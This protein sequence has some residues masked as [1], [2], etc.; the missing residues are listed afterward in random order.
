MS[1]K[2][3]RKAA[4]AAEPAWSE[5]AN[6]VLTFESRELPAGLREHRITAHKMQDGGL[7]AEWRGTQQHAMCDW[8]GQHLGDWP[9]GP[10]EGTAAAT[11]AAVTVEAHEAPSDAASSVAAAEARPASAPRDALPAFRL[12]VTALRPRSAADALAHG[13]HTV[14][15]RAF[16]VE[17]EIAAEPIDADAALV[18]PLPCVVEFFGRNTVTAAKFRLGDA[19]L[20]EVTRALRA[21]TA[22]L[23]QVSLPPGTYR[24]ACIARLRGAVAPVACGQ[25]PLLHVG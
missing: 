20:I 5:L 17:A 1:G 23:E 11:A 16:D 9:V 6:F 21:Y 12:H 15:A 14:A 19:V 22:V 24:L 13:V 25:G 18:D 4:P 8:I 7:T 3:G 10:V 2:P